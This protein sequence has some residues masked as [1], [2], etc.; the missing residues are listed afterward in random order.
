[1][2]FSRVP[3]NFE[4][5]SAGGAQE[6]SVGQLNVKPRFVGCAIARQP[7]SRRRLD[8]E[9]VGTGAGTAGRTGHRKGGSPR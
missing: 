8:T 7:L 9:G 4:L 3:L 6:I 1:M 2:T 5:H